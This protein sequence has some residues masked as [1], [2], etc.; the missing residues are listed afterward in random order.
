MQSTSV[1]K[2]L[3]EK[4]WL[5]AEAVGHTLSGIDLTDGYVH[6]S[7]RAQLPGTAARYFTGRGRV[8][9]LKFDSGSL[10]P[11]R[12]EPSRG[13]DLFPHLYAPLE[14]DRAVASWW[15]EPGQ[16]G[17]LLLPEDI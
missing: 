8:R 14:I 3:T 13:G 2:L 10:S 7:T 6:L 4:D 17:A 9:L 1:Y 11:L 5:A 12:W 16:D 15:L